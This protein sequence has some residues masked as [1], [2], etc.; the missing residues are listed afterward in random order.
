MALLQFNIKVKTVVKLSIV[1]LALLNSPLSHAQCED[2]ELST[3]YTIDPLCFG[4][5]TGSIEVEAIGGT[6]EI[7]YSI[8]P[9]S[10]TI[11]ETGVAADLPAGAYMIEAIDEEGCTDFVEVTLYQ[12]DALFFSD[13]G[14]HPTYCSAGASVATGQVYAGAY[15]GTG[16]LEYLWTYL[17]TGETEDN[18]TWGGRPAG[19]YEIRAMD[20]NG[21]VLIDTIMVDS[22]NPEASFDVISDDIWE[23]PYGYAGIAPVNITCV[24]TSSNVY[25]VWDPYADT[26]KYY[27]HLH[28]YADWI[29]TGYDY[30]PDVTYE[31]E[32]LWGIKL[33]AENS[34]GCLDTAHQF[35]AVFG[36]AST[37]EMEEPLSLN[38]IPQ[39]NANQ[40]ILNCTGV[41][42]N[43]MV[44]I[45][46]I[47]G[48]ILEERLLQNGMQQLPFD[49]PRG[50][51]LFEFISSE[52]NKRLGSG[53]FI[54]Q[55]KNQKKR[56]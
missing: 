16:S 53:K 55:G 18:T 19:D 21:C 33:V 10:F 9:D 23:I 3:V 29:S 13:I 27:W 50:V 4:E 40:I 11:S 47:N 49:H 12:P 2:F 32:N 45:Y 35:F 56:K 54:Y 17:E 52:N 31:Y 28:N 1:F 5:S 42:T 14:Y 30:E 15:G 24:N 6:G 51:Y 22:V 48:K 37:D 44:R 20:D 7:T 43:T 8:S 41:P 46:S 34:N 25:N 36:P 38:I 39:S 26:G